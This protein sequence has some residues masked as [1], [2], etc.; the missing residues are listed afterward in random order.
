MKI[1]AI[2]LGYTLPLKDKTNGLIQSLRIYGN[3][4]NVCTIT[5]YSGMDPEVN[6]IGYG[7]GIEWW[8]SSF[9]P[10]ARTYTLGVQLTF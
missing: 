9:Y 4:N 2:N 10:R 3:I 6:V 1:D 8:N 5:G 7:A